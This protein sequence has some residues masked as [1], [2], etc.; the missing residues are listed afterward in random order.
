V[1]DDEDNKEGT[2]A[3]HQ[4]DSESEEQPPIESLN[5]ENS[6]KEEKHSSNTQSAK[7]SLSTEMIP[8]VF[9]IKSTDC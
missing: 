2:Q 6:P 3:A 9:L 4:K 5:P 1:R 8:L 7:E